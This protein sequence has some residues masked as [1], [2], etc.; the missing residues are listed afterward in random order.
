MQEKKKTLEEANVWLRN[1]KP[2]MSLVSKTANQSPT[3]LGSSASNSPG[4]LKA[5]FEFRPYLYG[6]TRGGNDQENHG[7]KVIS[8]Q[9]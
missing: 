9:L 5:Q 8:P 4:T 7:F 6:E 2:M 1:R 3:A